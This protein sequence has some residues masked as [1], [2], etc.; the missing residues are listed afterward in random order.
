[1]KTWT[2]T[3]N[4]CFINPVVTIGIFDGVH[5][6]HRSLLSQLRISASRIYGETVV[7]TLWPH[8]RMVL[9]GNPDSLR[10]LTS[11][12]EKIILLEE[13]GIDHLLIIPFTREFSDLHSWQFVK[14]YLVDRISVKKL[15]VGSDHRL[16]KNKDG[17]FEKLREYAKN[18]NFFIEIVP[19]VSIDGV[20]LS[21]SLI[22][23]ILNTRELKLAN[24]YLGY[25]YFIQGKVM[26]GNKIGRKIGFP[27]ANVLPLDPHKLIP[28]DGVYAVHVDVDGK[29]YEGMLNIG[30]RPTI[31]EGM[32]LKTIE[33]NLFD[34]KGDIY[35]KRITL[36]FRERIRDEKKFERI[37]QLRNQ[38]VM[39]KSDALKLLKAYKE[40]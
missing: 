19:P 33:V 36:I 13:C 11:L 1:M 10:Y 39:D 15:L 9:N 26:G 18:Y 20:K 34:F 7:I 29:Q 6:G 28:L 27:T 17:D 40:K 31:E 8:P 4:F 25:D 30:F 16:G 3:D 22:R 24:K 2:D 23:E 12:E 21:S 14:S 35:D 37:E 5:A 32:S 38:L